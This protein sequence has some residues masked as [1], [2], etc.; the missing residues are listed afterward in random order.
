MPRARDILLIG[1][2]AACVA[3]GALLPGGTAALQDRGLEQRVETR[4]LDSVQLL[5][6]QD[7]SPTQLLSQ[8]T[9]PLTFSPGGRPQD[10]CTVPLTLAGADFSFVI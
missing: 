10:T 8:V 2:T 6:R 7:L 4:T 1:L 3:V 5:I 9:V